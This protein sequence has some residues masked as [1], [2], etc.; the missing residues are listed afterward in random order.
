M[1]KNEVSKAIGETFWDSVL[2]DAQ[3]FG[4]SGDGIN[5]G[6]IPV[7][8]DGAKSAGTLVGVPERLMD[9]LSPK[10]KVDVLKHLFEKTDKAPKALV[11]KNEIFKF[12]RGG[13]TLLQ[14]KIVLDVVSKSI[15]KEI[16]FD[17]AYAG[18]K[19]VE[20]YCT[21]PKQ[22]AVAVGD[23][24]QYGV[25]VAFSPFG[26]YQPDVTS[27]LKHL[28]CTNG[29][30]STK[31]LATF[32]KQRGDGNADSIYDWLE[33]SVISAYEAAD[34]EMERLKELKKHKLNG[35]RDIAIEHILQTVPA[36]L[37]DGIRE[38]IA[39]SSRKIETMYDLYYIV[40]Y[41][42]SHRLNRPSNIRTLMFLS[43]NIPDHLD[44]CPTCHRDLI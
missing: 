16:E 34:E 31:N 1:N 42:A 36:S 13:T 23:P 33:G 17:R 37:R 14:P 8:D 18:D 24:V 6:S 7:S 2:E 40:T 35:N 44:M 29:M 30:L 27:Y 10:L 21:G 19:V 25:Y 32:R 22:A 41:F 15:G 20:I 28:A 12:I 43:G 11:R 9:E 26:Y 5:Y 38:E 4:S 3:K 39:N